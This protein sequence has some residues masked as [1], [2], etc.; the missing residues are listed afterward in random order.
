MKHFFK[1]Q[2]RI[3]R[4]QSKVLQ[5]REQH[6]LNFDAQIEKSISHFINVQ[7]IRIY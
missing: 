3:I 6:H 1:T 2:K 5:L 4:E 7:K